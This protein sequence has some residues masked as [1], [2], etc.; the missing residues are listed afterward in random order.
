MSHHYYEWYTWFRGRGF[1]K[2]EAKTL[3]IYESNRGGLPR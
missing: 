3:A 1:T 2:S